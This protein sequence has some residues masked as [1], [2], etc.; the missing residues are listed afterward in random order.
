MHYNPNW[1]DLGRS[2][3][4]EVDRAVG[5]QNYQHLNQTIRQAVETAVDI[6][7]EAVRMA[8]NTAKTATQTI[9]VRRLY[10]PVSVKQLGA[11]AKTFFGYAIGGVG[12]LAALGLL[13]GGMV[14]PSFVTALV[15]AAGGGWMAFTGS[16]RLGLI[17]RFKTYKRILGTKTHCGLDKLARAVGKDVPFVRKDVTRMIGEGYFLEER[18]SAQRSRALF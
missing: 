18:K 14:V 8:Q 15:M 6:G 9:A 2:I 7:G 11:A 5:S 17:K 12:G 13:M 1:D 3:R 10:G 16:R 4:E